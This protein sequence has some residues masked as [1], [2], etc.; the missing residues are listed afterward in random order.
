MYIMRFLNWFSFWCFVYCLKSI[1]GI[2]LTLTF[3]K[4]QCHLNV[5]LIPRWLAFLFRVYI[6]QLLQSKTIMCLFYYW[7][8]SNYSIFEAY[9]TFEYQ[10]HT[11]NTIFGYRDAFDEHFQYCGHF[12][13][14][15]MPWELYSKNC[16]K[17][18][19]FV[20]FKD[21]FYC[22]ASNSVLLKDQV[23]ST[24]SERCR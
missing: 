23:F 22:P 5:Q 1:D 12:Y 18:R 9:Q 13:N 2:D 21:F 19:F 17:T 15:A 20:I 24:M 6:C 3:A 11:T 16:C 14:K 8:L 4:E 10:V 7:N